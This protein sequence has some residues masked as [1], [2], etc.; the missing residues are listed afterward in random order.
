MRNQYILRLFNFALS[1]RSF[2]N[3]TLLKEKKRRWMFTEIKQNVEFPELLKDKINLRISA[4]PV[5]VL[6]PEWI[7]IK[8]NVSTLKNFLSVYLSTLDRPKSQEESK[9]SGGF[10]KKFVQ[11]FLSFRLFL[12][13]AFY[14]NL[15][16]SR[17]F[18]IFNNYWNSQQPTNSSR[19]FD[20]KTFL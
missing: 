18:C 4:I 13:F 1:F 19:N 5:K 10:L 12:S 17:S 2:L 14:V 3:G 8:H 7:S 9:R 6:S 15:N 16:A 11:C 20:R